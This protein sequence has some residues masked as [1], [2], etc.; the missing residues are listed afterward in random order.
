MTLK[1]RADIL[2]MR[3][4]QRDGLATDKIEQAFTEIRN[5]ALEEGIKILK[6]RSETAV[7]CAEV[8]LVNEDAEGKE[9]WVNE[10]NT[11]NCSVYILEGLKAA[12]LANNAS[13]DTTVK[14][15]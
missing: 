5:E 10:S 15:Q 1:E 12:A 2:W 4:L 9:R 11:F 13:A 7:R 6:D 14:G 3:L 8:C